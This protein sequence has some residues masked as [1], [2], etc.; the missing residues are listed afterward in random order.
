MIADPHLQPMRHRFRALVSWLHLWTGLTA[1]VVFALLGL[2]GSVLTFHSELLL[3]QHPQL[4]AQ[5]AIADGR[6]LARLMDTWSP[7]GMR[8]IDVPRASMPVW[9]GYFT[10][11]S[12]RYFASRTGELLLVRN[13]DDDWLLWLHELHTHL[14]TGETGEEIV[15][16]AGWIACFMLLSGLYLWW[17]RRGHW[18]AHLR[19]HANPPVRRWLTWHRS[20]GAVALPVLLLVTACGVG[21]VYHEGARMLLTGLFGGSHPSGLPGRPSVLRAEAQIDW[22]RVLANAQAA[23]PD[24]RLSRIAV[25]SDGSRVVNFRARMPGEWHP[26]GRS[27][28]VVDGY[29]LAVLGA[30]DATTQPAGERAADAIYPLHIGAVGGPGYRIAVALAGLLPGFLIVTGFLFWRRRRSARRAVSGTPR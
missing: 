27:T 5:D 21:M 17:P 1:G 6:V 9:Q 23:L 18:L 20:A 24:A 3:A 16:V 12:R 19:P 10:D 22:V 25:P 11:D 29:D 13:P 7:Q 15:G 30:S 28:I 2:S 8:A 26:N 14:L 4:A